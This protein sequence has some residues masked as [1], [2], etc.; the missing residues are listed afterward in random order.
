MAEEAECSKAT[1]INIRRNLQQFGSVHTPPDRI[2][3]K[4]TMTPLIVEA[5]CKHLSE[6]PGP[7]L[8]EITIFL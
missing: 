2:G 3:Q 7:Y 5:L 6:K 4:R 1:I 8:D